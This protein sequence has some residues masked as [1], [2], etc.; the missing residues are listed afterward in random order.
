[1]VAY[2]TAASEI[3]IRSQHGRCEAI[4]EIE[5]PLLSATSYVLDDAWLNGRMQSLGS[6]R[7]GGGFESF[8]AFQK[9]CSNKQLQQIALLVA[10]FWQL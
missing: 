3:N 9:L 7:H 10:P 4:M 1:M 8:L 6:G 2:T 5:K